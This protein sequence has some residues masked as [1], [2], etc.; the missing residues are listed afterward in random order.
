MM[1]YIVSGLCEYFSAPK[2]GYFGVHGA[3]VVMRSFVHK[4]DGA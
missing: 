2:F 4:A 1:G 3:A